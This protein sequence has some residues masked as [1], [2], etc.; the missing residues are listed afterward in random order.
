MESVPQ[1]LDAAVVLNSGST[2]MGASNNGRFE[3]FDSLAPGVKQRKRK[4]VHA[5]FTYKPPII[6][7]GFIQWFKQLDALLRKN[8][9]YIFKGPLIV[10]IAAL[11][12]QALTIW[13]SSAASVLISSTL[14][15]SIFP[16]QK[17]LNGTRPESINLVHDCAEDSYYCK[18]I[19]FYAPSDPYHSKIMQIFSKNTK[20]LP[21]QDVISFKSKQQML[22]AYYA[23]TRGPQRRPRHYLLHFG[24]F[25]MLENLPQTMDEANEFLDKSNATYFSLGEGLWNNI[26]MFFDPSLQKDYSVG[27]S[28]MLKISLHINRAILSVRS[29]I[30]IKFNTTLAAFPRI[31]KTDLFVHSSAQESNDSKKMDALYNN[32][33]HVLTPSIL[34]VGAFPLL[35]LILGCTFLLT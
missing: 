25:D 5:M 9:T 6:Q 31:N 35:L 15:K 29:G 32:A 24:T 26:G 13:L 17:V 8:V 23:D 7:S 22:D 14:E 16:A 11:I 10:L 28:T 33:S 21:K 19:V 18:P 30:N 2:T 3:T 34:S 20:M 4:S 27:K 1:Q 12:M